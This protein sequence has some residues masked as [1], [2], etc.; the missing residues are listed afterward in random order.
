MSDMIIAILCFT[1]PLIAAILAIVGMNHITIKKIKKQL[2]EIK[3]LLK[4]N[5][6]Q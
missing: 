3:E 2:E 6:G 5:S 1:T 4:K